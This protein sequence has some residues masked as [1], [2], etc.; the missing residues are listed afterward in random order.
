MGYKVAVQAED[1][2]TWSWTAEKLGHAALF[3]VL[4]LAV[5][6]EPVNRRFVALKLK[7]L[8]VKLFFG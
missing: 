1:T 7:L 8:Y 2:V 4:C 3:D 5:S 6:G